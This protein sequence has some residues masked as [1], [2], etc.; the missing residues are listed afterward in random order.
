DWAWMQEHA[1]GFDIDLQNRSDFYGQIALQ[2]PESEDIMERVL[3]LPCKELSFYT[4]KTIGET[5]ISRTG[6]TGEDGFEVYGT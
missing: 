3:S 5:L 1:A 4:C 6:Y 2:G